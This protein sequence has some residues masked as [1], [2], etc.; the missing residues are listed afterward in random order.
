MI[1][2]STYTTKA[3]DQWDEMLESSC[4]KGVPIHSQTTKSTKWATLV[5]DVLAYY[6]T[7]FC[8]DV[9]VLMTK[10]YY[11]PPAPI[12]S[13]R[14]R[15]RE[16][17]Y[18]CGTLIGINSPLFLKENIKN[19]HNIS[20]EFMKVV[21]TL[22]KMHKPTYTIFHTP[23][24]LSSHE[25][26]FNGMYDFFKNHQ[27]LEKKWSTVF[28]DLSHT[29]E[30]IW[31]SLHNSIRTAVRKCE[32]LGCVVKRITSKEEF[33][34]LYLANYDGWAKKRF[35]SHNIE[36]IWQ[37][38]PD[39]TELYVVLDADQQKVYSGITFSYDNHIGSI[40]SMFLTEKARHEKIPAQDYLMWTKIKDYK[41]KK[42]DFF[43]LS[44]IN[45][46]PENA[47]E[48]NIAFF[49]KKFSNATLDYSIFTKT[50]QTFLKKIL[51]IIR[52]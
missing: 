39:N 20:D 35:E 2:T 40:G 19:S 8:D 25:K 21:H 37:S 3:P 14:D 15:L 48:K 24:P 29:E 27:F 44:G 33:E 4:I 50:R 45:P 36:H 38:Y 11:Y 16:I 49:K 6:I 5:H 51:G 9:P 23:Y 18:G 1:I 43:D 32:K 42:L 47:K 26:S 17:I 30:M 22:E 7:I 13:T 31:K 46:E 10:L 52:K 12:S 41:D 34:S 28:L